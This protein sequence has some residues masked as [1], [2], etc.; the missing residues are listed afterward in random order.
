[1]KTV[2]NGQTCDHVEIG[3]VTDVGQKRDHNEDNLYVFSPAADFAGRGML[4][5]VADG[6]GGH[7]GGEFASR[8][9]VDALKKYYTTEVAE[10]DEFARRARAAMQNCITEANSLIYSQAKASPVLKG[11]GTTL[12]TALIQGNCLQIG[13]VGDSRGYRIRNNTLQQLTNDHSLVAEQIRQGIISETEAAS[14]PAKNIITRALGTKAKVDIDFYSFELE[15]DDR[16]LLCSDG[17]HGVVPEAEMLS[18]VLQAETMPEACRRL[19]A[20][21]NE[22]GGPD[23]ITVIVAHSHPV[24]PLWKRLVGL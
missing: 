7:A 9:A 18:I 10:I 2:E 20:K 16:I 23:N 22:N 17:L 14:H 24:K 12:T 5:G 11:M 1:M 6:M 3:F 19:I 8:I 15:P 21:A 13:Q 4:F